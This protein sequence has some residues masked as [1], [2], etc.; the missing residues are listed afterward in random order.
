MRPLRATAFRIFVA[1]L[2]LASVANAAGPPA[3]G[4]LPANARVHG[5]SLTDLATAW[6]LWAFGSAPDVNPL[7]GVR[8]EQSPIDPRIYFLPV[9]LGGEWTT[10]CEVPAGTFLVLNVG[11]GECSSLEAEPF[12]GADE[13]SLLA[14]T[15]ALFNRLNYAEVG[16]DGV[17]ATDLNEYIVT[18]DPI[19]LPPNNLNSTESGLSMS[20]GYFLVIPPLSPGTHTLRAYDEFA[21]FGFQAGI[22]YTIGVQ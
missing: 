14:C 1:V 4:F 12:F 7:L 20:K 16:L 21:A 15:D 10:T 9:S 2:L 17:T 6:T 8:C 19:T 3:A 22:T 13:N 5:Y 18:T 11:L